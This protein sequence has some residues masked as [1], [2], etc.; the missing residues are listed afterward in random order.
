MQNM[1]LELVH[2][3]IDASKS[4]MDEKILSPFTFSGASENE[5]L[6]FFKPEM[7]Q[8]QNDEKIGKAVTMVLEK[9]DSN[10]IEVS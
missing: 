2:K 7:F 8:S 9:L 5:F 1:D 3:A 4:Q 10:G 6:V